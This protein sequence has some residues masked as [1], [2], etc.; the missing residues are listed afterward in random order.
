MKVAF[1][2][3]YLNHHQLPLCQEFLAHNDVEFVFVATEPIDEGRLKM[4]CENMNTYPFVVR[5]YED[6][7]QEA[8]ADIIAETYD[9][10]IF[11]DMPKSYIEKRMAKNLLSF[12]FCERSLK[13]RIMETLYSANKS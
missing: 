13:K 8:F 10:V 5:A 9:M 11:G 7:K 4:G 1:F 6:S 2:S 3:N 12:R